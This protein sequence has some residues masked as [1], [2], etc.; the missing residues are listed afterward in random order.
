[1][2]YQPTLTY[3]NV[4]LVLLDLTSDYEAVTPINICDRVQSTLYRV[5]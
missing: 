4:S 3:T 5:F 1:M 2:R